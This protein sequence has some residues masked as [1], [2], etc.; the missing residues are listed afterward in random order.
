MTRR[1]V[2]VYLAPL[3]LLTVLVNVWTIAL[4]VW[5]GLKPTQGNKR[6]E[7]CTS[8]VAVVRGPL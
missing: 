4:I 1:V 6:V 2:S 5:P 3:C 7:K 8:L